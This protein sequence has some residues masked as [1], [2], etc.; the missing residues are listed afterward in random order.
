MYP[1]MVPEIDI[2]LPAPETTSEYSAAGKFPQTAQC[3]Q[4]LQQ[5][6]PVAFS[7]FTKSLNAECREVFFGKQRTF[8]FFFRVY[9]ISNVSDLQNITII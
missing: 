8:H 6:D 1:L 3:C 9:E 5:D 4:I 7:P 2:K